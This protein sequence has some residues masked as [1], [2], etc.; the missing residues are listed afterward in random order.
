MAVNNKWGDVYQDDLHILKSYEIKD[1][2]CLCKQYLLGTHD[3]S[4]IFVGTG[5]EKLT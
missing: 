2:A 5:G 3:V 4:D 1:K